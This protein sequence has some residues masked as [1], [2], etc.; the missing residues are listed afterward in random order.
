MLERTGIRRSR[1]SSSTSRYG[2]NGKEISF[3]FRRSP[4]EAFFVVF[5]KNVLT[6]EQYIYILKS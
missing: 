5:Y 2:Q 6:K 1:L 3:K 4:S